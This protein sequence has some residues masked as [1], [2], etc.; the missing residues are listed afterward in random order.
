MPQSTLSLRRTVEGLPR[1][2]SAEELT[3][4]L[5]RCSK[6]EVARCDGDSLVVE[7][8]PDRLDL[9]TEAGLRHHLE[10]L[11]GSATGLPRWPRR[12][13]PAA[14]LEIQVDPSV[15][16]LRPYL[17]AVLLHAPEREPLSEG[18][19]MEAI[20]FQELLH[21]TLGLDRASASLGL[22]PADRIRP[23]VTYAVQPVRGRSF[24]P[25]DGA[26]PVPLEEFLLE[27]PLAQRYGPLG[28]TGVG[29]LV[30]QDA[31]GEILSL[32]PI[33][34]GAPAGRVTPGDR[35]LLVE[36]TGRRAARVD[37]L[38]GM[39]ELPFLARGWEAEPVRVRYPDRIDRGTE[40]VAPRRMSLESELVRRIGG[41]ALAPVEVVTELERARLG[42]RPQGARLEVEVPPWRPD[43][44]GAVDLVE[45]VLLARG[46][47]P[48]EGRLPPSST[49]GRRLRSG[50]LRGKVASEL[51]GQGFVPL[52]SPVLVPE[53]LVT[54]TGR[55]PVAI[56]NP[57]S[58]EYSR[59]RDCLLLPLL[60]ALE[61]NVRE[62]YPQRMSEVGPVVV[63]DPSAEAGARTIEHAALL[64]A[65]EGAGFADG[66]SLVEYLLRRASVTGV[67][68]S[69]T[70]PGTIRGRA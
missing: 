70:L 31:S 30:L 25:F 50:A 8:T 42:A 26:G 17:G 53:R 60:L 24:S 34:N 23:P 13:E 15:D 10:G 35:N 59:L 16:P 45:E 39:L 56:E 2:I 7:A 66:A 46:L 6:A 65:G 44:Q 61:S 21:A 37:E 36:S 11:L 51:L 47:R 64:L 38:L 68:E 5:F 58:Q 57:V 1:P 12:T 33:L 54:W 4:L 19:L 55:E 3:E 41:V 63:A 48:E 20:R 49:R 67:R 22:Y 29:C 40:R 14:G 32:P 52:L 28:R 62:G 27:H 43:L 9:L 69:A 18:L